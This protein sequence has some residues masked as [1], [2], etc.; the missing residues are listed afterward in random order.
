LLEEQQGKLLKT[1]LQDCKD[2]VAK[3]RERGG[4][5]EKMRKMQGAERARLRE[6]AELVSSIH[7]EW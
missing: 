4:E 6:K 3:L 2:E 7:S 5:A 1:K